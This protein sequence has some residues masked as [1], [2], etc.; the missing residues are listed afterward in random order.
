MATSPGTAPRSRSLVELAGLVVGATFLLV[1][2]LGF[3]PGITTEGL[4]AAGTGSEAKLL[5]LFQVSVLHNL[6]HLSFGIVGLAMARTAAGARTFLVFGGVIYVVLFIYGLVIDKTGDL[7]FLPF[8]DA[9]DFLHLGLAVGMLGLGLTLG[10]RDEA[11][12]HTT[13]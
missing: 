1:G 8:N 6:V 4:E 7:N 12:T 13:V 5:G 11:H 10:R 2:I 9:D 3:V